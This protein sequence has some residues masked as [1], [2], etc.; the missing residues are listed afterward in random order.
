MV[1][2][3]VVVVVVVVVIIVV[4]VYT[5]MTILRKKEASLA[6]TR[7]FTSCYILFVKSSSDGGH[8]DRNM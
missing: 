4:A 6:N 7:N 2:V 3:D 1:V 5:S 8:I